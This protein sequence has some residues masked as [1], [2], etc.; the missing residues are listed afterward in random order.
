MSEAKPKPTRTQ[1]II[2]AI[3]MAAALIFTVI[4]LILHRGVEFGLGGA[5]F[6]FLYFMI[7]FGSHSIETPPQ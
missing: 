4:A 2:W 6:G 3:P 1:L 7:R 5:L